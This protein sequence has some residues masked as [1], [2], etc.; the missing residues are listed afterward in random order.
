MEGSKIF[1][2]KSATVPPLS[3]MSR[4]AKTSGSVVKR[5]IHHFGYLAMPIRVFNVNLG[6]I[7]KPFLTSLYLTPPTTVS[8]V[9]TIVSYP[10]AFTLS[11]NFSFG[12]L[13][14]LTYN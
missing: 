14:R 12:S 1:D 2:N 8:T 11:T 5:F 6:G 4:E 13:S 10:E 7:V 3:F 9:K